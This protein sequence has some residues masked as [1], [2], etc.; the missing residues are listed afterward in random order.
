MGQLERKLRVGLRVERRRGQF[1]QAARE[2]LLGM[3]RF[4]VTVE[5]ELARNRAL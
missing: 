2:Q 4:G 5:V 3:G 1:I